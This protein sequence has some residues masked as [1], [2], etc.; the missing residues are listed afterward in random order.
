MDG[1]GSG[2]DPSPGSGAAVCSECRHDAHLG[3]ACRAIVFYERGPSFPG[4][5][6][7]HCGS[8]PHTIGGVYSASLSPWVPFAPEPGAD[9]S[10][11]RAAGLHPADAGSIPARST[12]AVMAER[13]T[14]E[15][16]GL[17]PSRGAGSSPADGT[18]DE[19]VEFPK[20]ARLSREVIIT[21][22]IDGTNAQVCVTEDGRV[23]AGSRTRWITPAADNFGFAMWVQANAD[24]LRGLGPGRHY[25]E[26]WGAKIGRRYGLTER[27]FSLFNVTRW[28][29]D[30][31]VPRPACCHIVPVLYRGPFSTV[32]VD[33][34]LDGMRVS[35]SMAAPGFMQPEGV[36]I[37]HIAGNVGFKKTLEKDEQWKGQGVANK[38]VLGT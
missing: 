12:L 32:I 10:I 25:G 33:G 3:A 38:C 20:I 1:G 11:G 9:S 8:S 30:A 5:Y 15:V 16:E 29:D 2:P 21:E 18:L 36:V 34:I 31:D 28:A 14:R 23:L 13:Q 17:V 24:A 22:K 26:W 27:R 37:F 19:F 7:C 6:E 35:G 4:N